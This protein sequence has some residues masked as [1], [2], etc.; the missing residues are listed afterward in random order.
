MIELVQANV[1]DKEI[2]RNLLEKYQFEF[3]Q[4]DNRDVNRLG[5]YGYDYLDSY[6]TEPN[7]WAF[8]ILSG[9][10][11]AGFAMVNDYPEVAEPT[12]YSLSEFCVLHKYRRQG[13]GKAA[14]FALYDRFHGRWQLMRHPHN[15]PSVYFWNAV[16]SEYTHGSFRL[17]LSCP[18]TK[19]ADGTPGDVFFFDNTPLQNP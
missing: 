12:D 16:V 3:S 4:W 18:G 11:L 19:Y 14:A 15:I 10:R 1:E 5:L 13:V 17:I 7:R 8:F 2:L 9:G 6:W